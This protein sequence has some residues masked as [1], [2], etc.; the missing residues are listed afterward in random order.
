MRITTKGRYAVRAMANLASSGQGATKSI[1][2]ICAEE[3][4]SPEFLEQIFYKL[5]K[6]GIIG[7]T[8]GPSG[9]FVLA[10]QPAEISIKD[11]FL[12][13]EEGLDLTPC[14]SCEGE[15]PEEICAKADTCQ[16]YNVW[17]E[18]SEHITGYFAG[19][20]LQRIIDAPKQA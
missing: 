17:R 2:A 18:T 4:I 19:Y 14:T 10:R 3:G 11:I 13:V 12:A 5:K 7:S 20:S 9:G 1:R 16:V 6:A 8:R 15:V